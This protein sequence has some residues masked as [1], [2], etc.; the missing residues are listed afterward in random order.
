MGQVTISEL[1]EDL[2]PYTEKGNKIVN[3]A[4]VPRA[5]PERIIAICEE[6]AVLCEGLSDKS[7]TDLLRDVW[8]SRA[9]IYRELGNLTRFLV[10]EF[11]R[12]VAGVEK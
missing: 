7:Q 6:K 2:V 11:E 12:E 1:T 3:V 10:E 9:A 4:I 5:I 8:D